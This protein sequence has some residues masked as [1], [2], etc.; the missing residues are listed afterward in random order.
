MTTPVPHAY[1]DKNV[2]LTAICFC[3]AINQANKNFLSFFSF[4]FNIP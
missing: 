3:L 4:C 1:L 2:A